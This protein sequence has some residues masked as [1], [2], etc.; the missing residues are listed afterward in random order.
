[1]PSDPPRIFTVL[2]CFSDEEVLRGELDP[3]MIVVPDG[4]V[5]RR[6]GAH[7]S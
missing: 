5:A 7:E 3:A 4:E 1:M 2:V 6:V